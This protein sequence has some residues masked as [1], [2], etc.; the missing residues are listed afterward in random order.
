M[1]SIRLSKRKMAAAATLSFG[2]HVFLGIVQCCH[3]DLQDAHQIG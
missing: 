1:S 2:Y 3:S